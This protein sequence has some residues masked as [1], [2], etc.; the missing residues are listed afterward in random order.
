MPIASVPHIIIFI[1]VLVI[2]DNAVKLNVKCAL[3]I[4]SQHDFIIIM[5]YTMCYIVQIS[6]GNIG[7]IYKIRIGHDNTGDFPGWFLDEVIIDLEP[8]NQLE[9]ALVVY[10]SYLYR[11]GWKTYTQGRS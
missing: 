2:V 8:L 3:I 4:H 1:A 7:E 5:M 10:A 11:F 6:V 9:P